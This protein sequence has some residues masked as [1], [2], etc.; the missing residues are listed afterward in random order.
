MNLPTSTP[1]TSLVDSLLESLIKIESG[2]EYAL[3]RRLA[4]LER[5]AH[6]LE[7]RAVCLARCAVDPQ[8]FISEWCWTFDPR[9]KGLKTVPFLLFPRQ[10]EYVDWLLEREANEEDGLVEKS[11]DAGATFVSCAYSLWRWLFTPGY[12]IGFGSRKEM[13]VDR[14]GDPDSI[15]EKIR[16]ILRTL[17][18]WMRPAGFKW[19]E[20][21]TFAKLLNPENGS[22]ITGEAGDQIGRGG[23][24]SLHFN[25]EAAFISRPQLVDAALS[26]TTRCRIDISTP[27][28]PGNPFAKKRF[29]GLIAV[30]RFHWT[31]DPRKDRA[32][33]E[34]E[35]RRLD[36]VTVAQEIDIDYNASIEGVAVP[37]T[38]VAA[39]I[40]FEK[41]LLETKK[42]ELPRSEP[43]RAGLDIADEGKDQS[44]LVSGV[45]PI[46][47]RVKAWGQKNTTQTANIAAE[48]VRDWKVSV[49]NYDCIGVGA[50]V[51]GTWNS[52]DNLGFEAV[53]VNVG[54][55]ASSK[56]WPNGKKALDLFVSLKAE[57]WWLVRRRF[58]KTYE[59]RVEGIEHPLEELISLPALTVEGVTELVAQI[60]MPLA[61]YNE[62]GKIRIESKK[63]LQKRGIKSPDFAEALTLYFARVEKKKLVA[64]CG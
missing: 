25:D 35:L 5:C 4:R 9:L 52:T 45:G 44:V 41:W 27:N 50:G 60:S 30:F 23:R 28:G 56:K 54:N 24:K 43:R 32:W 22:T 37:A 64:D 36:R 57:L 38:W 62:A 13:L 42:R 16:S 2:P 1:P 33:Y 3:A 11:R 7:F 31:Q 12:S 17:P 6:D 19:K 58:E 15:F 47:D 48:Y 34:K 8:W 20:H 10:V 55:P 18:A 53:A 39:A 49:I 29:S 40:E 26:Q 46:I 61:D 51:K 21:A 14:A 63:A 59:Y